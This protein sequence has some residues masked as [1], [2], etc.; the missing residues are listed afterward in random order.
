MRKPNELNRFAFM[1]I[2]LAAVCLLMGGVPAMA[3]EDEPETGLKIVLSVYSGRSNP[4][5]WIK[6][7]PELEKLVDLVSTLETRSEETF[8]Y[9]EWNRLG[10]ASF[11][12]IPKGIDKMPYAVHVWRDM[13]Y[14]VMGKEGRVA[15][16]HGGTKI[17][18][19]LVAQAERRD[20]G[21]FF[22]VYRRL[23]K[24]GGR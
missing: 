13:V 22:E 19:I 11:W 23:Q 12:I 18:D 10:Y 9:S 16:A 14:I 4:T 5:W 20:Q 3:Q 15:Y 8:K 6:P 1:L 2:L 7:G 17:Y 24:E 21:T